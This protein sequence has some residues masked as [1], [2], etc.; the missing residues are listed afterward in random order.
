MDSPCVLE[1]AQRISCWPY[2]LVLYMADSDV[3][4]R[5]HCY[6]GALAQL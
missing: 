4:N 2:T 5:V 3:C 1:Y 6:F